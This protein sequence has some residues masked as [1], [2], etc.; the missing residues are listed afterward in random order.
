MGFEERQV[1][2]VGVK[3]QD[4][5]PVHLPAHLMQHGQVCRQI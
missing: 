2:E 5:E 3:V 1:Q 4:V